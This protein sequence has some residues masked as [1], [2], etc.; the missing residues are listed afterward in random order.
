MIEAARRANP[1]VD[2]AVMDAEA[3]EFAP[4]CFDSVIS[5]CVVS[6]FRPS[7]APLLRCTAS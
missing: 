5:L 3:L 6:T 1:H 4:N 7:S 2:L